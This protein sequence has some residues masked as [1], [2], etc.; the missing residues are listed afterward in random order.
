M[1]LTTTAVTTST[2]SG[3]VVET[4]TGL[5]PQALEIRGA[6]T[7]TRSLDEPLAGFSARPSSGP[8][9]LLVEFVDSSLGEPNSWLWDFGDD[10]TSTAQNP[11]HTYTASGLYDVSLTVSNAFG[12][13]THV[14]VA[15][16]EVTG[17]AAP[18][19][20]F[21]ASPRSGLIPLTVDFE[22]RSAGGPT[23]WAWDFGDGGG[24]TAQNPSHEYTTIGTYTVTLT[25]T[26]TLGSD[27]AVAPSYVSVFEPEAPA[28]DFSAD[29]TSGFA[30]LTVNFSDDSANAPTAWEWDFGDGGGSTV[31][32][33]DYTYTTV[34][35][36]TVTLT[37]PDCITVIAGQKIYLPLVLRNVGTP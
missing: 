30:P 29:P 6:F 34:G 24:S 22:D 8:A 13:D 9:P 20:Y 12:S 14:E 27:T 18:V 23:S 25:V 3:E 35:M 10:H 1:S 11:E 17:P 28:A 37:V 33:P 15:H 31:Q 19:A 4:I 32:H 7:L 21:D 2:I 16:I 36:F 26:N 5:V